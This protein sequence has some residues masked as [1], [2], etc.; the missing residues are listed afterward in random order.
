MILVS[1]RPALFWA[2]RNYHY[3]LPNSTEVHSSHLLCG[4]AW[5]HVQ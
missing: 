2:I 5:N 3:S 4:A 1:L